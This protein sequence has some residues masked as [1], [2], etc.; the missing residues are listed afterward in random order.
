[1]LPH[2]LHYQHFCT[3][4]LLWKTVLVTSSLLSLSGSGPEETPFPHILTVR[5]KPAFLGNL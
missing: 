5:Q 4:L 3:L 2:Y 1:L